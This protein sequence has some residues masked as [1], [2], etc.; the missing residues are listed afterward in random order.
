M[1]MLNNQRVC[2]SKLVFVGFRIGLLV[3]VAAG[4]FPPPTSTGCSASEAAPRRVGPD[5]KPL[6]DAWWQSIHH[7]LRMSWFYHIDLIILM[8]LIVDISILLSYFG[9]LKIFKVPQIQSP[10]QVCRNPHR[11]LRKKTSPPP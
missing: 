10:P 11:G 4:F 1:A 6:P 9:G 8:I 7:R 3:P 2:Y 5:Q